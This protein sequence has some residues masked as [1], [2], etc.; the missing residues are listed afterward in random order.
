M[1]ENK[2]NPSTITEAVNKLLSDLSIEDKRQIKNSRE[3]GLINF[4]FGLGMGIRNE[5]GLWE[6]D[7]KLYENCKESSGNPNLDVD[8][9]SG[10]IIKA[11]WER[12]QKFPP[13]K[14]VGD[15][16]HYSY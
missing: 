11:L 6:K 7:S 13:P 16:S 10:M 12:L 3:E 14:L 5:F 4:H 9:A 2:D 1:D 15:K 8:T